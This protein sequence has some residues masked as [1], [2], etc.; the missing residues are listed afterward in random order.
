[1]VNYDLFISEKASKVL[2]RF[3]FFTKRIVA[4]TINLLVISLLSVLPKRR[5][6]DKWS[7]GRFNNSGLTAS[8]TLLYRAAREKEKRGQRNR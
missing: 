4:S 7:R 8:D 5:I 3:E 1:M 2:K 6:L